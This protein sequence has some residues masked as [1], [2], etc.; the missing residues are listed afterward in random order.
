[1]GKKHEDDHTFNDHT[2]TPHAAVKEP[3]KVQEL[4]VLVGAFK[5]ASD[6]DKY[7]AAE[8]AKH[9]EHF[10]WKWAIN[11]LRDGHHELVVTK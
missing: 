11:D 6:T 4:V 7:H 3:P 5:S 10:G 9:I 2:F 1:M 8:L